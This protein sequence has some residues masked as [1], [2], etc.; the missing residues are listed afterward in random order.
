MAWLKKLTLLKAAVILCVSS[1]SLALAQGREATEELAQLLQ[2]TTAIRG[3]FTQLQYDNN[4]VLLDESSGQFAMLRPGYFSWRIE[5]PDSQ[6][7][8]ATPEFIWHH[9]IDLETVTRRPLA[10]AGAMSPLQ[11]LSGNEELL[12]ANYVVSKSAE[13]VFTLTPRS[14]SD[15]ANPGFSSL[16]LNLDNGV[17]AGMDMIDALNQRV[18]IRFTKIERNPPLSPEDFEFAPP[19]GVDLFY[20]DQ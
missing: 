9:D 2:Q 8:I 18:V 3:Q 6:L 13:G 15:G 20:Y 1:A 11:I 16:S 19:A 5:M 17:L 14:S 7:I 12:R 4:A 10:K